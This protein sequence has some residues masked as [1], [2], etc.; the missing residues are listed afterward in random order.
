MTEAE[1]ADWFVYQVRNHGLVD[2]KFGFGP[3]K[4]VFLGTVGSEFLVTNHNGSTVDYYD[5][6]VE[7]EDKF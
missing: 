4:A 5:A 3:G 6:V 7:L 1:F 2:M